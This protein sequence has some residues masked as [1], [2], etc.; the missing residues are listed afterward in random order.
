MR[1]LALHFKLHDKRGLSFAGILL[2]SWLGCAG[3][4][5]GEEP[6]YTAP[7]WTS[8]KVG[9][10]LPEVVLSDAQ[11]GLVV[12]RTNGVLQPTEL[13][14]RIGQH[15]QRRGAKTVL[16]EGFKGSPEAL[17]RAGGVERLLATQPGKATGSQW[18]N[19]THLL[20]FSLRGKT[21]PTVWERRTIGEKILPTPVHPFQPVRSP[22]AALLSAVLVD[23]KQ[24]S[25]IWRNEVFRRTNP[26][27]EPKLDALIEALLNST[28]GSCMKNFGI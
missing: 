18:S 2:V 19:V 27:D 6:R 8:C 4:S 21:G 20:L 16:A 23:V 3:S 7:I 10:C 9:V 15:L 12:P 17:D 13:S 26:F 5:A 11:T 24:G 28:K 1:Y 25:V 22:N 14:Q